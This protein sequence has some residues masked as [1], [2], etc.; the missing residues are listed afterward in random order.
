KKLKIIT[1]LEQVDMAKIP[2]IQNYNNEDP[3][4]DA[5]GNNQRA[6]NSVVPVNGADTTDP[7]AILQ[8]L[9]NPDLMKEGPEYQQLKDLYEQK[10]AS[11]FGLQTGYHFTKEL[12]DL[13][14]QSFALAAQF[15]QFDYQ[16]NLMKD[17]TKKL[18]IDV[19]LLDEFILD[20]DSFLKS[21]PTLLPTKGWITS[22]YGHRMSPY[23][24]RTKMHEG[25]DIGANIGTPIAA[26][27]DGVVTFTGHKPGFGILVQIDH[28]Y[29]IETIFAHASNSSVQKGQLIHRG[30]IIAHVGNTGI[31]TGPHCHYEIRV[32]GTP[33][34]PLY[35]ILD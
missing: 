30:D 34:D 14:K 28:G 25:L 31:S 24:G 29:G 9:D 21:T 3:S 16:F 26:P 4:S 8:L 2:Y 18:E 1:G 5:N 13:T 15:A 23:S 20:R 19:H 22:F 35:Y 7:Q 10:M 32:N 33:V 11:T 27:A 17:M 12:S 6:P